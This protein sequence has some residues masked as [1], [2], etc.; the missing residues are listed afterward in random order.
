MGGNVCSPTSDAEA[1]LGLQHVH[2]RPLHQE[3]ERQQ[4]TWG[5]TH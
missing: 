5:Q 1:P 3:G 4:G 2:H